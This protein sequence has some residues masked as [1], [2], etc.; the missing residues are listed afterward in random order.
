[1]ATSTERIFEEGKLTLVDLEKT[2]IKRC[3]LRNLSVRNSKIFDSMLFGC[4]LSNCVARDCTFTGSTLHE[5]ITEG[6]RLIDCQRTSAYLALRGFPP[7]IRAII[8]SK[9][10]RKQLRFIIRGANSDS[11]GEHW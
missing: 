7:E 4:T 8:F 1:M 5:V 2:T 10:T 3:I 9:Y 11:A 6:G